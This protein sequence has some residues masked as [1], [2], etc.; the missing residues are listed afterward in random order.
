MNRRL[1]ALGGMLVW[2]I[3]APLAGAGAPGSSAADE[4]ELFNRKDL[5]GWVPVNDGKYDVKDGTIVIEGGNGWLR[6][7]KEYGDFDLSLEWRADAKYRDSG[8]YDSGLFFRS[9]LEGKPWPKVRYQFGMKQRAEGDLPGIVKG[10]RPDLVKPPGEW[11]HYRVKV[12]G[13]NAEGFINGT[14]VWK[15]DK[16]KH[17]KGYIGLQ[18]EGHR[19]EFRNIKLAPPGAS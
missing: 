3:A 17:P 13:T 6:T 11:N 7:E 8:Q 12:Q 4:V 16:I 10:G 9:G 1:F 15:T 2:A 5:T 14:S 19:F 18:T